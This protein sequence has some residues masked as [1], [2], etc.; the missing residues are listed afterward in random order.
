MKCL[1]K[2]YVFFAFFILVPIAFMLDLLRIIIGKEMCF[3]QKV[4]NYLKGICKKNG[5]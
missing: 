2:L 3:I 4:I 1:F 5:I